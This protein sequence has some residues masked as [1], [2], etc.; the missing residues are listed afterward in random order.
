MYWQKKKMR[1]RDREHEVKDDEVP[2][3]GQRRLTRITTTQ[4]IVL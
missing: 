3:L 2:D 1:M 4:G